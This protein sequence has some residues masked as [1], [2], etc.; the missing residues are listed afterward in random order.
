MLLA[1]NGRARGLRFHLPLL[2]TSCVCCIHAFGRTR[3]EINGLRTAVQ[4]SRDPSL[5]IRVTRLI[6]S[7]MHGRATEPIA[8]PCAQYCWCHCISFSSRLGGDAGRSNR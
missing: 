7:K 6:M 1:H 8:A 3:A 2:V 4:V 5:H